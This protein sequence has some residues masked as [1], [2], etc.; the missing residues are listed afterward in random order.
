MDKRLKRLIVLITTFITSSIF[1]WIGALMSHGN[2]FS[3]ASLVLGLIG[4]IPG[5]WIGYKLF[6]Y[7]F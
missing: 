6:D 1:A 2:Y 5:Y 3:I 4:L 7:Y